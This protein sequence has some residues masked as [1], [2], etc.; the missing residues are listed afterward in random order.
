MSQVVGAALLLFATAHL[1]LFRLY[2]P[3]RYTQPTMRVLLAL[4]A[5]GVMLALVDAALRRVER[6]SDGRRFFSAGV[7]RVRPR[8]ACPNGIQF[9]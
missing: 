6:G 1:L 2:L 4:A 3:N 5:G 8:R 9:G 7:K